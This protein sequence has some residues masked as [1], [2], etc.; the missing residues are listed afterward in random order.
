MNHVLEKENKSAN[1]IEGIAILMR[2]FRIIGY[3]DDNEDMSL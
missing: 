3:G 2:S 1:E